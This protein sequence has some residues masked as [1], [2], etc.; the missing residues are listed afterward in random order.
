MHHSPH[1]LITRDVR[2]SIGVDALL[3]CGLLKSLTAGTDGILLPHSSQGP[4]HKLPW[5][6]QRFSLLLHHCTECKTV[7][8]SRLLTRWRMRSGAD[9]LPQPTWGLLRKGWALYMTWQSSL[10]HP[11]SCTHKHSGPLLVPLQAGHRA[12]NR[13]S[14]MLRTNLWLRC[15]DHSNWKIPE[16]SAFS[17]TA[18]IL[19]VLLLGVSSYTLNFTLSSGHQLIIL[20]QD[21]TMLKLV[22]F[23]F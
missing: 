14:G 8:V 17:S 16:V 3:W 4:T 7:Q 1:I 10:A 2:G 19:L 9:V 13:T 21:K 20:M 6:Q 15:T 11:V 5:K 12:I 23:L 22:G 18:L